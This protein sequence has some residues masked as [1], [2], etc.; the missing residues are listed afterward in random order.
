LREDRRDALL[1]DRGER[2]AAIGMHPPQV[3]GVQL[4]RRQRILDLV[5]NLSGHLGPGFQSVGAL[6][7]RSL[8]LQIASHGIEIFN[9]PSQLVG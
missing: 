1:Q 4:N 6:E 9:Q 5:C 8:A 3:L 2:F 7:F